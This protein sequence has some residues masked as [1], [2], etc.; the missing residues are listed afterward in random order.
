M[1]VNCAAYK[2][3]HRV[4]D[5]G[6]DQIS[7]YILQPGCFVWVA[8]KEPDA[9]EIDRMQE[10]F[11]LH[12]LAVEDARKG[13]QSPK[14]E[15][16]GNSLFV[17]IHTVDLDEN[18]E[19]VVGE[20]AIFVGPNYILSIRRRTPI[21]FQS[22]RER[23]EREPELLRYG[24]AFV[25]YALIDAVVDRYF[26]VED[27]LEHELE[28]IEDRIFSRQ[29][30]ARVNIEELYLLKRQLM[31]LQHSASPLVEAIGK[32][33]GGRVPQVCVGMQ[34]YYR[35]VYDHLLRITKTIESIR[36]MT[37]TAIQVNLSMIAVGE[38]EVSKKLASYAALFAV[39]TAAAGI[40]GMNFKHM[41]ELEWQ[42]GYPLIIVVIVIADLLL[43]WR[44]RRAGWM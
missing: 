40:Y 12:P 7:D 1:L 10:E 33:Q 24:S 13:H 29:I 6:I 28:E 4:A 5:L 43:W 25:L 11:G 36:E 17:V 16:Y 19:L 35:D 21:G 44:F 22:V 9:P 8:L 3:G 32:L 14:I 42:Y 37:T 34:E 30:S 18:K 2:D 26:P 41:P 38:S 27:Q 39:P 31:R 15:E 20:V 23:C